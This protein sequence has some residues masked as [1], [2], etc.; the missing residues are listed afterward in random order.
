MTKLFLGVRGNPWLTPLVGAGLAAAVML[1]PVSYDQTTAYDVR[2][3]IVEAEVRPEQVQKIAA[4]MKRALNADLI[5]VMST[6]GRLELV[7]RVPAG[8][9]AGL[10]AVTKAFAGELAA[11]HL[12]A[13]TTLTP[14]VTKVQGNVYA[15]ATS[16]TININIQRDGRT[17]AQIAEE[18]KNQLHAAGLD[19]DNVEFQQDG[20]KETLKVMM[21]NCGPG[22]GG[23]E[24][25]E[26]NLTVDG[27]EPQGNRVA[28]RI[29]K[30]PGDTDETI[31][32]R[33]L[34]QLRA[35]G[36]EAEVVIRDGKVVSIDPIHH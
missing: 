2:V 16:R 31:R 11:R 36:V 13:R 17:D 21:E 8:K 23:A 27:R 3:A 18:I 28:L 6:D 20:N 7:A 1:F 4:E 32:Q 26:I 30:Q 5:N 10:A 25:P 19:V 33:V 12:E 22:S 14:V 34:D 9:A 35:Q 15:M 29:E 24:H